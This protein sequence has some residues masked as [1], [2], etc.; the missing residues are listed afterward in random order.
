MGRLA[1]INQCLKLIE[2]L[3]KFC[4]DQDMVVFSAV[5]HL[6]G[7]L[8]QTHRNLL[9]G[10]PTTVRQALGEDLYRR[11]QD[12]DAHCLL[13]DRTHLLSAL[14]VDIK[15]NALIRFDRLFYG[16]S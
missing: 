12:V 11:R 8:I 6:T 5:A 10:L 1:A 13:K 4:I 2:R 16:M 15:K 7:C 3:I 14:P 9:R